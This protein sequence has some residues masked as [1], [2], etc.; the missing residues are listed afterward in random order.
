M[1]IIHVPY[2]DKLWEKKLRNGLN[3]KE[4]LY[5]NKRIVKPEQIHVTRV[6]RENGFKAIRYEV[7]K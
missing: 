6:D 4:I 5:M 1:D 7:D 3:N 2:V